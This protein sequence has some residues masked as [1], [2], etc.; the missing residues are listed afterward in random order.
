MMRFV[1]F[2]MLLAGSLFIMAVFRAIMG[3]LKAGFAH[4]GGAASPAGGPQPVV[5]SG[6]LKKCATCGTYNTIQN[7][8][9]R[10]HGVETTYYCSHECRARH[11][12]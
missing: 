1:R 3:A 2:M 10:F 4:S 11:A 9:T 8:V 6:E 5:T 12:A 7:C